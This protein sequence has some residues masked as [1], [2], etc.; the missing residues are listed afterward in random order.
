M[1]A[2][3]IALALA[4][5]MLIFST[6]ATMVLEIFN[7]ILRLRQKG[8]KKMLE[9]FYKT[10][11]KQRIQVMLV[12]DGASG[13]DMPEFIEK[14]TSMTGVSHTLSTIEFIRQLA[15]TDIGKRLAQRADSEIDTL[16]D[17]ITER[18]EDHGR[19]ASQLFR[20]NSQI[21]TV[22]V[23]VIIALF[24]NINVVTLFRTFQTNEVLTQAIADQ[25]DQVMATYQVQAELLK[26]TTQRDEPEKTAIDPDVNALKQSMEKFKEKVDKAKEL[27][28]PIGWTEDK[29]FNSEDINKMGW[30]VWI[31]TTIFTGFLIG[32]GGPFWFDTV[33]RLTVVSQVTGALVRQP[34]PKDETGDSAKPEITPG[35]VYPEDPKTAFKTAV[36]AQ[37]IIDN[38]STEVGSFLGPKALR[39]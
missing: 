36:R 17:D 31:L 30:I 18:Y 7:K 37:R 8:L 1:K 32:L 38:T 6:L 39:L 25:A 28:L 21:G 35:K 3:Q 34:P 24:L 23:S 33:K 26:A 5:S 12:R 19:R 14:V 29:F 9:A 4:V 16:I 15:T 2:L 22:I 13:E 11:V 10:E 27:G 20:R